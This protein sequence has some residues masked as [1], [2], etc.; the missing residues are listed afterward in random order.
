VRRRPGG[1]GEAWE[2]DASARAR[3]EDVL[4]DEDLAK[5][6]AY[7]AWAGRLREKRARSKE[8]IGRLRD[9]DPGPA[10]PSAYWDPGAVFADGHRL[11]TDP[12]GARPDPAALARAF[13]TL[14]LPTTA[15]AGEVEARYRTL[16]R[17]C[18]PDAHPGA[19]EATRAAHE[20]RFRQITAARDLL[21]LAR[22]GG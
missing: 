22:P 3:L 18:H 9:G 4:P 15:T 10:G 6:D 17:T 21:R 16:A 7:R 1:T 5:A 8:T 11:D 2:G 20:D 12:A 14:G 19:D 13:T